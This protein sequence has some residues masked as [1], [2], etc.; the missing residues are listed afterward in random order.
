MPTIPVMMT[1]NPALVLTIGSSLVNAIGEV[2]R[3]F[4]HSDVRRD[5]TTRFLSLTVHDDG[6]EWLVLGEQTADRQMEAISP[7]QVQERLKSNVETIHAGIRTALHE[8]RSHEKLIEVGLGGSSSLPLD[9]IVAAD[10]TEPEAACLEVLL[11]ALGDLLTH[12]SYARVHLLLN[13]AV[14]DDDPSALAAVHANLQTLQSVLRE[15]VLATLPQVYLFDRYKEGV[16]EAHD[17]FELRTI[18]GNFLLAL[19]SGGLAQHLAHQMAQPDMDEHKAYFC[20]ASATALIFDMQQ[21]QQACAMRLGAEIIEAEFHSKIEP[22]P[23]QVNELAAEFNISHANLHVWAER[24]CRDT[25]F[26]VLPGGGDVE[27]HFADLQ[28]E[29]TPMQDWTSVIRGYDTRFNEMQFPRQLILIQK[30]AGELQ[31]EFLD[32]LSSFVQDL[33]QQ[34]RLYPGGV[35][36]AQFVLAKLRGDLQSVQTEAGDAQELEAG[37]NAKLNSSL[38]NLEREIQALP[39]PPAWVYRLP[40][41]L[42]T[43]VI[44]LFNMIFLYRELKSITE[45]RQTC[46]RLIEQKYEALAQEEMAR[47]LNKLGKGWLSALDK[48]VREVKRLQSA[49]DKLQRQFKTR[50]TEL[51]SSP[52]Q[53]RLSVLDESVL[54]WAYYYGNR[55]QEGFRRTLLGGRGFLSDWQKANIKILGERLDL[56]CRDVYQPLANVDLEEALHHRNGKDANALARSLLQ[57]AVPLLRPNFDQTGSGMSFQLRFFQCRDPLSSSLYPTFKKDAQEWEVIST[58]DLFIASCCR[59]RMLIPRSALEHILARG[60]DVI[61]KK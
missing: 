2:R 28:F 41:F 51:I 12:E 23:A 14:F 42:R 30:S 4:L 37:W 7:A 21:L 5:A 34:S 27:L 52:S 53:F 8:L 43:P 61:V 9:V 32:E 15:A 45:M 10:L 58:D 13:I 25:Q 46:V 26:H 20:A 48:H 19:L 56:F 47:R 57:G 16:W 35:R 49:L 11:P 40:P 44:Q 39:K 29:D 54:T 36:A 38:E 17:V 55:P 1:A 50:T 24:L 31:A 33:P 18:L 22:D 59:V 6:A 60:G 3:I